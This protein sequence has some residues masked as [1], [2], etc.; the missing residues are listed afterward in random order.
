MP[1]IVEGVG[2]GTPVDTYGM[3]RFEDQDL[4]GVE[5]RECD[6]TRARLVGVVMRDAVIDG[7]VDN[8]VVN[9]VEVTSYVEAE[10]DRRHPVRLL[11][12]SSDP[13]E[14]REA[15]R[16]LRA[17][18]VATVERLREMPRGSKHQRVGGEWSAVETLRHL[19]FVHDSWFRRCCLGSTQAFTAI[20]LASD[21]VPDQEGQGLDR[22]AA[23]GLNKVLAVRD[24]Q[25]AELERWLATVTADEL[26]AAAPVPAGPG[27]PP[28]ARGRSVLECLHTV[29]DEEWAHHSFCVR[30]LDLLDG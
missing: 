19:V 7:L 14:L 26:S 23:P 1:V 16:Q 10:L 9:G 6:L 15:H 3:A 21:F 27:W 30:D 29:L 17:D 11:I 25:A 12:R 28:Y 2:V 5:F 20:G 22:A 8:L 18:W 4:T 24:E 13:S